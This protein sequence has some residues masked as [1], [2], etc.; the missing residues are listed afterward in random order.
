MTASDDKVCP[1]CPLLEKTSFSFNIQ[2]STVQDTWDCNPQHQKV[3][4][5]YSQL[6]FCWAL[7]RS[8]LLKNLVTPRTHTNAR[9][10]EFH[11]RTRIMLRPRTGAR[12]RLGAGWNF[13]EPNSV[14]ITLPFTGSLFSKRL[15]NSICFVQ[16]RYQGL[17]NEL[18]ES[19]LVQKR[20]SLWTVSAL[21]ISWQYS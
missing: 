12:R 16:Y 10:R 9:Y 8:T 1:Q 7:Q 17:C 18:E 4:V 14:R 5:L 6:F 13:N 11:R 19:D 20:P 15:K 2:S 3:V 21:F